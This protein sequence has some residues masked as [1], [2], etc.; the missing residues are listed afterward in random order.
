MSSSRDC[1]TASLDFSI[2]GP[3]A[4]IFLEFGGARRYFIVGEV[5]MKRIVTALLI[6]IAVLAIS[7]SAVSGS[8][9]AAAKSPAAVQKA[10]KAIDPVC[11]LT[12]EKVAELSYSYK[13]ETYY[14]C[15]NKDRDN[16]KSNPEKYLKKPAG[17]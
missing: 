2:F 9:V 14:F 13:G 15:S 3:S 8:M 16:F 12:V 7:A 5:D 6:A 1:R 4:E 17:R 10:Q 11:G